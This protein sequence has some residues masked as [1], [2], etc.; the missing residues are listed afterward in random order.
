MKTPHEALAVQPDGTHCL[1]ITAP[2]H[3]VEVQIRLDGKVLWVNV[4]GVLRLRICQI[5]S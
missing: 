4:D 2:A 3:G 5:P 1:D